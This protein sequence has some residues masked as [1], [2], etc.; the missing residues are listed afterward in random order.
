VSGDARTLTVIRMNTQMLMVRC[1]E[2]GLEFEG[3]P[4]VM[5]SNGFHATMP[6]CP[7]CD[8]K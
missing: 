4:P 1:D 5:D 3:D 8:K 2:C 6:F 7:E